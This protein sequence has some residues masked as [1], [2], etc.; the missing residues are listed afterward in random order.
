MLFM[1]VVTADPPYAEEASTIAEIFAR[2]YL[3]EQPV[4]HD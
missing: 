1:D 3:D 2:G 4:L